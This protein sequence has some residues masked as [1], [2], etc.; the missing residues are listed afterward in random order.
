M[1]LHSTARAGGARWI[2]LDVISCWQCHLP[3]SIPPCP[4]QLT[5]RP[6]ALT[7]RRCEHSCTIPSDSWSALAASLISSPLP[8]RNVAFL[9]ANQLSYWAWHGCRSHRPPPPPQAPTWPPRPSPPPFPVR[10]TL[11]CLLSCLNGALHGCLLPRLALC[12]LALPQRLLRHAQRQSETLAAV[13]LVG[14]GGS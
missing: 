11:L 2:V 4:C 10:R 8:C 3:L 12:L 14:C 9:P 6:R 13:A 1:H 5:G 7:A